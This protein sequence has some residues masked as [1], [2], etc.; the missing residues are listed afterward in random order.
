MD[1]E[2]GV[3]IIG[4]GTPGATGTITVG[5]VSHDVTVDGTGNWTT[6]YTPAELVGGEY[7]EG[8]SITLTDGATW[9]YARKLVTA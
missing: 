4:T 9:S 8:V 5:G 3:E 1:Y 2:D 6:T 7:S